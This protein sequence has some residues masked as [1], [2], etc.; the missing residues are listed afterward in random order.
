VNLNLTKSHRIILTIE[1]QEMW[2]INTVPVCINENKLVL[3]VNDNLI[4]LCRFVM[5]HKLDWCKLD[6]LCYVSNFDFLIFKLLFYFL[7]FYFLF[8][9]VCYVYCIFVLVLPLWQINFIASCCYESS[10]SGKAK[11]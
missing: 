8:H 6:W 7:Y 3:L 1:A 11:Q 5:I 10:F 4:V 9:I 2:I